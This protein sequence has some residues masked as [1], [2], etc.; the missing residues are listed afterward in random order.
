MAV[1]DAGRDARAL[2][3]LGAPLPDANVA[4]EGAARDDRA[5]VKSGGETPS[6]FRGQ[7]DG[8]E[9]AFPLDGGRFNLKLDK[10]V[11]L[12][13]PGSVAAVANGAL[14]RARGDEL[15]ALIAS[16]STGQIA[17][18]VGKNETD[19]GGEESLASR[20]PPPAPTRTGYAYWVTQGKL[21]RRAFAHSTAPGAAVEALASDALDGTRVAA[22]T[23]LVGGPGGARR[24]VAVYIARPEKQNDERTARLWIE[25]EGSSALSSDGS[26][27]SNVAL[28]PSRSGLV[29]IM[30][31]ARSAMSPV[32][33]R[34]ILV[35]EKGPAEL[36]PDVVVFVGPSPEGRTE[37][38][39]TTGNDGP[40]AFLPFAPNTS[41]FGLASLSIGHEPH[42]DAKVQWRMYPNGLDPAPVA[43]AELCGRTW[44]A[45]VR[46]AEALPGS[47]HVLLLAPVV[48]GVFG[49]E[50][51]AAQG[52]D[53]ATVSLAPRDEGGAWLVWVGNGR[54]FMRAVRCG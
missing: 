23:V 34:T 13:P 11:D 39:A 26:G 50:I 45:Y 54:S 10:P 47:P 7:S 6:A 24:D 19:A 46:P 32:H 31:D 21:V 43:A 53:F 17:R 12:G 35:R 20:A 52:F 42:L 5:G 37:L 14:F 48:S 33:A 51:S 38:A 49:P 36:G 41:S 28:V 3:A 1:E 29:A 27:A 44:V 25:G 18:R 2:A 30:L 16:A 8:E 4:A 22:E 15:V 9:A 40:V